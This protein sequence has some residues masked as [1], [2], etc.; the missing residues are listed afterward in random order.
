MSLYHSS[1]YSKPHRLNQR[2]ESYLVSLCI[3]GMLLK[4]FQWSKVWSEKGRWECITA[5]S[6]NCQQTKY[7]VNNPKVR[8]ISLVGWL[9]SE[10]HWCWAKVSTTM[11]TWSKRICC[12]ILYLFLRCL[13]NVLSCV[14]I[15][16]HYHRCC[17]IIPHY[18]SNHTDQT[19]MLN[20]PW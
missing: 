4:Y 15:S 6:L 14:V 3:F 1:L 17:C 13:I 9:E 7:Q 19:R 2:I 11:V 18:I 12:M 16:C 8:N 5:T 10:L 20:L